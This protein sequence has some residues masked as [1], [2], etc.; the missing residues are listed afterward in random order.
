MIDKLKY[1]CL[2]PINYSVYSNDLCGDTLQDLLSNMIA[3][4]N[5]TVDDVNNYSVIVNNL[6][7]YVKGEGLSLEVQKQLNIWLE[8]G[9]IDRIINQEIFGDL[10]DRV[11]TLNNDFTKLSSKFDEYKLSIDNNLNDTLQEVDRKINELLNNVN[12]IVNQLKSELEP[13]K[14]RIQLLEESQ[15]INMV[16]KGCDNTGIEDCSTIITSVISEM[17][18]SKK[19]RE[20]FFP[21]GVYKISKSITCDVKSIRIQIRG[22]GHGEET[23]EITKL[24]FVGSSNLFDLTNCREVVCKDLAIYGREGDEVAY[25]ENTCCFHT[26][27]TL[28]LEGVHINGFDKISNW[29]GGYYHKFINCYFN[30]FNIGFDRYPSYNLNFMLCK[31]HNFT[32]VVNVSGG[33][34]PVTFNQCSFERFKSP[35][36]KTISSDVIGNINLISC[37]IENYPNKTSR[38]P[39]APDKITSGVYDSS[40]VIVGGF[41]SITLIGNSIITNGI[42][43]VISIESSSGTTNNITSIGNNIYYTKKEGTSF[44]IYCSHDNKVKTMFMRDMATPVSAEDTGNKLIRYVTKITP[45]NGYSVCGSIDIYNP[46]DKINVKPFLGNTSSRPTTNLGNGV[47][48]YDVSIKKQI[49]WN[50]DDKTWYDAVG[51]PV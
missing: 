30:W 11:N 29:R 9:T 35:M 43:R 28:I 20:M 38:P 19:P 36:I 49:Y 22:E 27:G 18:T 8:D 32:T 45:N 6:V 7:D 1:D 3:T 47:S 34:G 50:E 13:I 10:S 24:S 16:A 2:K 51:D 42:E 40:R 33:N 31:F 12:N 21:A 44:N 26:Q 37:Y 46:F 17:V 4:I 41:G 15:P 39:L 23:S 14:K 5:L 48:Y 25:V